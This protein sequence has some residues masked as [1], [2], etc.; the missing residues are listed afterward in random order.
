MFR[1]IL[2]PCSSVHSCRS[3]SEILNSLVR[4]LYDYA[5]QAFEELNISK[6]EEIPVTLTHEDGYVSSTNDFIC[7]NVKRWWEGVINEN[8]RKKKGLFPSN[9]VEVIQ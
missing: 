3:T 8:G 5:S 1:P 6:G 9:F 7:A 2:N 4:A